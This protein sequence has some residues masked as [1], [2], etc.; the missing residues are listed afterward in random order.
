MLIYYMRYK[1]KT[2]PKTTTWNLKQNIKHLKNQKV[3]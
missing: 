1:S 2:E 3:K